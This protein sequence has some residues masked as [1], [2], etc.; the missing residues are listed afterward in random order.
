MLEY[1]IGGSGEDFPAIHAP[2]AA[3]R[4]AHAPMAASTTFPKGCA[5]PA[6][7]STT[8]R[9][10]GSCASNVDWTGFS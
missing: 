7:A 4:F 1:L 9:A 2:E 10:T 3:N 5:S 8:R 6:I